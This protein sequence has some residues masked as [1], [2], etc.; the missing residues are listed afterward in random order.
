MQAVVAAAD[1]RLGVSAVVAGNEFGRLSEMRHVGLGVARQRADARTL[2]TEHIEESECRRRDEY[3]EAVVEASV[4]ASDGTSGQRRDANRQNSKAKKQKNQRRNVGEATPAAASSGGAGA[5]DAD[6][7]DD[8]GET[9]LD[10]ASSGE[11]AGRR[12]RGG[13]RKR[14]TEATNHPSG[15]ARGF[16]HNDYRR[17]DD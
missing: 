7:A 11:G 3:R 1:E 14:G 9:A 13:K 17:A 4:E 15:T 16:E 12:P 10:A 8:V 2:A 5:G 6:M